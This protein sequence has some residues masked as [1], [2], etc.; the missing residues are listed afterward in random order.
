MEK[1]VKKAV[2]TLRAMATDTFAVPTLSSMKPGE[3]FRFAA[4]LASTWDP[5][6]S[7]GG[8]TSVSRRYVE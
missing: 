3:L 7:G 8:S 2:Q 1:E 6:V 5:R 4:E